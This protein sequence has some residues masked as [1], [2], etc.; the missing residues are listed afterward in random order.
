[1]SF[2]GRTF[3]NFFGHSMTSEV[4]DY[5]CKVVGYTVK[6]MHTKFCTDI[7]T[8]CLIICFLRNCKGRIKYLIQHNLHVIENFK[9]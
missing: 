3:N 2:K 9:G 5:L 4:K 8:S 7:L 1:M 6:Y